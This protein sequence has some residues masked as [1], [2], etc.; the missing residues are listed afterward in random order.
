MERNLRQISIGTN[1][2]YFK[3]KKNVCRKEC[4][5]KAMVRSSEQSNLTQI[6]RMCRD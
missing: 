2:V 3:K 4:R 5:W 1:G 6:L